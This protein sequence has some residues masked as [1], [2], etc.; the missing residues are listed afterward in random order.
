MDTSESESGSDSDWGALLAAEF[1]SSDADEKGQD[2]NPWHGPKPQ[3]VCSA[4]GKTSTTCAT[5]E[6]ATL[7]ENVAQFAQYGMLEIHSCLGEETATKL[8]QHVV[9][10]FESRSR[11]RHIHETRAQR[12]AC[13]RNLVSIFGVDLSRPQLLRV[14]EQCDDEYKLEPAMEYAL[15][16]IDDAVELPELDTTQRDHDAATYEPNCWGNVHERTHRWDL[17]LRLSPTVQAVLREVLPL[18]APVV[19]SAL[20][21]DAHLVELSS[22]ISD[23]GAP[24]QAFSPSQA[25]MQIK[26]FISYLDP[27]ANTSGTTCR[28][29][30][31][32][33]G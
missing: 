13:E 3:S 15:K 32:K 23:P 19:E 33:A 7:S 10:L 5:D 18:V 20:G 21:Q 12:D 17:K 28:C 22:L 25:C 4:V 24:S 30:L 9:T 11:G 29:A 14:L 2:D 1:S 26:T 6:L 27:N 8:R 16:L 31:D